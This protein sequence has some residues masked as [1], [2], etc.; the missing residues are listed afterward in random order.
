MLIYENQTIHSAISFIHKPPE[1]PS[2]LP[3]GSNYFYKFPQNLDYPQS[4]K[5]N[6]ENARNTMIYE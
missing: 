2:L 3:H 5:K 1:L 4:V 6:A